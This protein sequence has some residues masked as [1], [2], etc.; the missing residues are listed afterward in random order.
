MRVSSFT[1]NMV[2]VGLSTLTVPLAFAV[3]NRLCDASTVP[4]SVD[5]TAIRF[6]VL[7]TAYKNLLLTTEA[8]KFTVLPVRF[9]PPATPSRCPFVPTTVKV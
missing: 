2:S 5:A 1:L 6:A 4:I 3:P 7:D 9:P 8:T